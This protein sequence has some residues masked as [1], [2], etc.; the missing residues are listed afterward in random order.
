MNIY[1]Y[2]IY[3]HTQ[4]TFVLRFTAALVII[5]VHSIAEDSL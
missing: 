5:T 3:T 1:I 4:C 2:K